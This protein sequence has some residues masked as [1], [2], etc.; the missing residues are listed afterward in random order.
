MLG[1]IASCLGFET[2]Q[3]DRTPIHAIADATAPS[4]FAGRLHQ[5]GGNWT[6]TGKL[7]FLNDW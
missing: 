5:T 6:A 4:A 7:A 1:S 2:D 3:T